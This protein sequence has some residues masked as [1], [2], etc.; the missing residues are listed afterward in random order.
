[1]RIVVQRDGAEDIDVT[2]GVRAMYDLLTASMDWG[3]GFLDIESVIEITRLAEV[4]GFVG[5]EQA[6]EQIAAYL[7]SHSGC[8]PTCGR[9][10]DFELG[11]VTPT[12]RVVKL[13]FYYYS[14]GRYDVRYDEHTALL[15]QER[16]KP[17]D[18]V[19]PHL[20]ALKALGQ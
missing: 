7:R 6:G 2:E 5:L 12:G 1:M 10:G 9:M 17:T 19:W 8:C 4:M 15:I 13:R 20:D 16:G 11:D 18:L 14:A 3:S